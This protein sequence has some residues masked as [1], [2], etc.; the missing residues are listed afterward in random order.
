MPTPTT[1]LG[2]TKK[3]S[4]YVEGSKLGRDFLQLLNFQ[5]KR[6]YA[7][8][9]D[10]FLGDSEEEQWQRCTGSE[11]SFEF[12]ESDASYVDS[13]IQAIAD[14]ERVGQKP[15]ILIVE[16]TTSNVG[17]VSKLKFPKATLQLEGGASGKNEKV[18]RKATFKASAPKPG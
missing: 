11:G 4:I 14:A 16:L 13:I 9:K 18:N 15:D 7:E 17:T 8:G 2:V 5:Y 1:N 3:Y 12:L 6:Q 10:E